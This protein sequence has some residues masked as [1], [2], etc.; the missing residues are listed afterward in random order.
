[1][2]HQRSKAKNAA[3]IMVA[4]GILLSTITFAWAHAM[5][6]EPLE[7]GK[8]QIVFDG[9]APVENAAVAVYDP[10]GAM[11]EETRAD[12]SGY[13]TYDHLEEPHRIVAEDQ[14]GHRAEWVVGTTPRRLPKIP[15]VAGVWL[16]FGGIALF[17]KKRTTLSK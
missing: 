4:A 17:F 11:L 16:G 12:E 2:N 14:V 7:E 6:V 5:F 13:Y 1:M 8:V 10:V 15:V 9:G 3:A